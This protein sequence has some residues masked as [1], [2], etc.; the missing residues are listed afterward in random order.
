[1]S[2]L[3]TN[4][5]TEVM[6]EYSQAILKCKNSIFAFL[7]SGLFNH[8]IF[9]LGSSF[10]ISSSLKIMKLIYL[11]KNFTVDHVTLLYMGSD[12]RWLW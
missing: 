3:T 7:R 1:M 5:V 10:H 4:L 6:R 11:Y 8:L 12:G 2:L 9:S